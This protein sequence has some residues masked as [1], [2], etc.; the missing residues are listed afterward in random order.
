MLYW[1]WH[2]SQDQWI[3]SRDTI[4]L[5]YVIKRWCWNHLVNGELPLWNDQL[6]T[7]FYQL[8]SPAIAVFSPITAFF[9]TAFDSY[10]AEELQFPFFAAIAGVGAYKLARELN[11]NR[12]LSVLVGVAYAMGG[13]LLSLADRSPFFFSCALYPLYLFCLLRFIANPATHTL[14]GLAVAFV[15]SLIVMNGDWTA[16]F[17]LGLCLPLTL[18]QSWCLRNVIYTWPLA[19]CFGLTAISVWPVFENLD[20]ATRAAGIP[21]E[22]ASSFSLHPMRLFSV[23]LPELWGQPYDRSFWGHSL[24]SGLYAARFWFHSLYLGSVISI[25]GF[26]GIKYCSWR[27]RAILLTATVF[28][29]SLSFGTYSFVHGFLYEYLPIYRG[30]RYPEKFIIFV[31]LI[32]VFFA[33]IGLRE[34]KNR[35]LWK[36]FLTALGIWHVVALFAVR[37]VQG[38]QT[39]SAPAMHHLNIGVAAHLLAIIFVLLMVWPRFSRHTSLLLILFTLGELTLY[40]PAMHWASSSE[41]EEAGH[42]TRSLKNSQGRFL[43]DLRVM[44]PSHR[45]KMMLNNWPLLDG[46]RDVSGYETIPPRRLMSIRQDQLFTHLDIWARVLQITDVVTFA[47]PREPSLKGFAERGLILP[48]EVDHKLN[49]ALLRWALPAPEAELFTS[50]EVVDSPEDA[51]ARVIKRGTEKGSVIL[52]ARP[53]LGSFTGDTPNGEWKKILQSNGK[54]EFHVKAGSDNIFVHRAAFHEGWR[55]YVDDEEVPVFRADSL[56]RAIIVPAGEHNVR[57][58]FEPPI[59][60]IALWTSIISLVVFL[61]VLIGLFWNRFTRR[62]SRLEVLP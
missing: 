1:A 42:F 4:H 16:A 49:L 11:V 39:F 26:F 15:L 2:F 3:E 57:F 27:A 46:L 23:F 33:S 12:D 13:L 18:F 28:F 55:A 37:I 10:L 9:Y 50:F 43:L 36:V 14:Y 21:F 53:P 8:A 7:G 62:A 30:L 47:H 52:E 6:F 17:L 56:S 22:E 45:R 41:F 58:T 32:W 19:L 24:S 25:A 59:F 40:A 38:S 29:V 54:V 51:L 34:I 5:F 48:I 44:P 35:N 61:G 60:R 20:E 31:G